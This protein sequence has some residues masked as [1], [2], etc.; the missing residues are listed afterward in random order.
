MMKIY[1]LTDQVWIFEWKEDSPENTE[2][3]QVIYFLIISSKLETIKKLI[4]QSSL[5]V[6]RTSKFLFSVGIKWPVVNACKVHEAAMAK[7][8][9]EIVFYILTES[10]PP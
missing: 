5:N 7:L 6:V 1:R 4:H 9:R 3:S 10:V 2:G 8:S